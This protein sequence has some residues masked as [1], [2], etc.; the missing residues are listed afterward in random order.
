MNKVTKPDPYATRLHRRIDLIL[1]VVT[2]AILAL[3]F[4]ASA[5]GRSSSVA[6]SNHP[7]L[8][9]QFQLAGKK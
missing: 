6:T 1:F 7:K 8:P 5:H 3:L 4:R 9:T 2:I